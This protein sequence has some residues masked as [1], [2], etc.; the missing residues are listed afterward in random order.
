MEELENFPFEMAVTMSCLALRETGQWL[1]TLSVLAEDPHGGWNSSS[2]GSDS[3]FG[4]SEHIMCVLRMHT[5][6]HSYS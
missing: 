4:L 3:H 5:C 1:G 6:R 2:I